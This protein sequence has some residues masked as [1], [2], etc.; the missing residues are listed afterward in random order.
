M[1]VLN[2]AG[3]II[4]LD[5]AVAVVGVEVDLGGSTSAGMV[6]GTVNSGGVRGTRRNSLLGVDIFEESTEPA[7]LFLYNSANRASRRQLE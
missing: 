4:G 6:W 5:E 1:K 7:F 3:R 2:R